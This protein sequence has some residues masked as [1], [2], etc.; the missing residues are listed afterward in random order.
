MVIFG[1]FEGEICGS[2][3]RVSEVVW[4][5]FRVYEDLVFFFSM[6]WRKRGR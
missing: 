6:L 1:S 5:F 4:S 3:A 2:L